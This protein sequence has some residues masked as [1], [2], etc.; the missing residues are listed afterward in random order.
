MENAKTEIRVSAI[1]IPNPQIRFGERRGVQPVVIS[2]SRGRRF[3]A[4]NT[5]KSLFQNSVGSCGKGFWWPRRRGCFRMGTTIP[6]ADC[7]P[8]SL[9]FPCRTAI[10]ENLREPRRF[11]TADFTDSTDGKELPFAFLSV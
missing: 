4:A 1:M 7:D 3:S 10:Y 5:S 2:P 8:F 6:K 11:L 9:F